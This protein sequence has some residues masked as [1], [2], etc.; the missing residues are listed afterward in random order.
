MSGARVCFV[1][2]P[3]NEAGNIVLLLR[4]LSEADFRLI[5][6]ASGRSPMTCAPTAAFRTC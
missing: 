6:P 3:Y 2:S 5:A 1:I 4:R